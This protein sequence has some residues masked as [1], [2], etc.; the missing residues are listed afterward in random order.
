MCFLR[1]GGRPEPGAAVAALEARGGGGGGGLAGAGRVAAPRV[2]AGAG[3][4]AGD[5]PAGQRAHPKH[6]SDTQRTLSARADFCRLRPAV[7]LSFDAAANGGGAL[8]VPLSAFVALLQVSSR[9]RSFSEGS[10]DTKASQGSVVDRRLLALPGKQGGSIAGREYIVGKVGTPSASPLN[11]PGATGGR[12]HVPV[13]NFGVGAASVGGPRPGVAGATGG[14][15]PTGRKA[16]SSSSSGSG[17]PMAS[18]RA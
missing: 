4:A 1:A 16:G 13:S 12:R 11:S 8:I 7:G 6:L 5:R 14:L 10:A 15:L 18:I 9:G 17:V 3:A 2:G